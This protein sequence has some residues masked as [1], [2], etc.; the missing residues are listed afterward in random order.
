MTRPD[1]I[2]ALSNGMTCYE[3]DEDLCEDQMCLRTGCRLRNTRL[4]ATSPGDAVR[5]ALKPFA[6]IA[7]LYADAE[8][9]QS[10]NQKGCYKVTVT[11]GDGI[12][13]LNIADATYPAGLTP[14]RARYIAKLLN[15][16]AARIE[17]Q[18]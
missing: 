16:S 5:E 2:A 18:P 12:V 10:V 3:R 8:R 15:A 6:A 4:S 17:R 7:D 11:D 13:V 9:V 14:S 1:E